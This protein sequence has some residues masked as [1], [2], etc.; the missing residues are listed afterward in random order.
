MID[1]YLLQV[2]KDC[3]P[4]ATTA[5]GR[6]PKRGFAAIEFLDCREDG[7]PQF[8]VYDLRGGVATHRQFNNWAKREFGYLRYTVAFGV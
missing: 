3:L 5:T 6:K 4:Y 8:E 1:F 2:A 7:K